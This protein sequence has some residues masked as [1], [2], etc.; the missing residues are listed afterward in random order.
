MKQIQFQVEINAPAKNAWD[1]LWEDDNYR[2]W[3]SAFCEGS[4]AVSDWQKGGKIHFLTPTGEGMYSTITEL[5]PY[6]KMF[7]THHGEIKNNEEQPITKETK[8]WSGARENYSLSE[9]NGTTTIKVEMDIVESHAA[10][11]EDA[12]PKGLA[13]VKQIAENLS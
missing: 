2:K 9:N 5:I 12:F 11:F 10:Y 1:A 3:T 8:S 7:F 6:E 13:I 4:Y